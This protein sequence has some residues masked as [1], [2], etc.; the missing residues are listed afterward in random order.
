[1]Q[2]NRCWWLGAM[3]A[4]QVRG[5]ERHARLEFRLADDALGAA[6]T[7]LERDM[8]DGDDV[9]IADDT[10]RW[11]RGVVSGNAQRRQRFEGA[12]VA[13]AV[14]LQPLAFPG[15]VPGALTS[16]ASV[17]VGTAVEDA[18]MRALDGVVARASV[19][20]IG[21]DLPV[22][23]IDTAPPAVTLPQID[24]LFQ[25]PYADQ[26]LRDF[27]WREYLHANPDVAANGA[28][29]AHAFAHF[30]QQGYYE[31]RIFD[32]ARL[33][34]FDGGYYR[35][36]YPELGLRTDAEAQVHYCYQ[37]WYEGRIANEVT[38][39]LHDAP[40]HVFQ[41]G[42][43]GSHSIAAGLDASAWPH[44]A[45][46]LHWVTDL[47][48][49]YPGNH[50]PYPRLL[51]H[52]RETPVKVISATRE[53]VSWTLASLFQ[54]EPG[55]LLHA[56]DAMDYVERHFWHLAMNGSRWFDHQYFCGLDVYREAFPHDEG[57][58]RIAFG[59]IDLMIYR[60]EDM[61]RLEGAFARFLGIQSFTLGTHNVGDEKHYADLYAVIR[62][63]F[64]MPGNVLARLYDTPFMR[65]F[66]SDDERQA[67]YARWVG[68]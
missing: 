57:C 4:R 24:N 58:A 33:H 45:V 46:H 17:P 67:F 23:Q 59:G 41:M 31:R 52:P 54:S 48:H 65:H 5:F 55:A 8:G 60:Q 39:W 16:L 44:G 2:S 63:S 10:G 50:L 3:D 68:T 64:R 19:R 21:D 51:V 30:F 1:M 34:G 28:D 32:P 42:K 36:R 38:G 37:G 20:G 40:L 25:S 13:R 14:T 6:A 47:V 66:Y 11:L 9:L 43:V 22:F 49:G 29:E 7:A 27:R 62:R 26:I 61:P 12:Y 56:R 35:T 53:L 18:V 15:G